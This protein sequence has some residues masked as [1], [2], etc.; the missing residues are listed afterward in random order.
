MCLSLKIDGKQVF[1][2]LVHNS[3]D[4]INEKTEKIMEQDNKHKQ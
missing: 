2:E 3:T 4:E 1:Q